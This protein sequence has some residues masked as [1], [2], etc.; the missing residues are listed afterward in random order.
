MAKIPTKKIFAFRL[1][2][3]VAK[4]LSKQAARQHVSR[5]KLVEFIL[6]D[7][8]VRP[9]RDLRDLL[10]STQE[11]ASDEQIDLFA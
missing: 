3:S 10:E 5:N 11:A 1:P 9:D 8:C 7:Y 6:R 2:D 4:T